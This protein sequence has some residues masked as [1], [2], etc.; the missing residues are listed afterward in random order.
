[1]GIDICEYSFTEPCIQYLQSAFPQHEFV[2]GPSHRH[3]ETYLCKSSFDANHVDGDHHISIVIFEARL[4]S[5]YVSENAHVI[6]DD[7]DCEG[8]QELMIQGKGGQAW[9]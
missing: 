2:K 9:N 1:M 4:L 6:F 8:V 3:L 5:Q 7:W